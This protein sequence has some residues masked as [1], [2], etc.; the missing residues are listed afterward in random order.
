MNNNLAQRGQRHHVDALVIGSGLAGLL[1]ILELHEKAPDANIILVSKKNLNESNSWYAQGGISSVTLESDSFNQ[2]IKDTIDAGD[3]LCVLDAVKNLLKAAPNAIEKLKHYGVKFDESL[4]KEGG[5]SERRIHHIGDYTGK[6]IIQAL[7]HS[8]QKQKQIIVLENHT[9]VNLIVPGKKHIPGTQHEV[10][11]AYLLNN[12]NGK[13]DTYIAKTVVLGTGGAGKIYRYTSN[14][15]T[16][17][18]DGIA[19]AYRA[20]A[21]IGNME[22]YQFHP[23]VLHHHKI[24]NFLIT[25]ALRGEGAYLLHPE[26]LERFMQKYDKKAELA[27][28]DIVSRAI[29]TEIELSNKNFVYLD[30]RHQSREFLQQHFP[31]IFSTLLELGIDMS[32]DLIPV[33]PAAHYLCGGILTDVTGRTDLKRLYAI[34]ETAFTG[35]HGANRLASNSLLEA[36]VMAE[37]AANDTVNLLKKAMPNDHK[38]DHDID[39]WDSQSV[40]DSRRASQINAHWRGLRGE[41]TSYAGIVRTEAGLKDLL[42]LIQARREMIEDYYWKYTVTTDLIELR[43]I[44]LVA[45]LIVRSALKRQESRGGHYREDYPQKSY[46][47]KES[48]LIGNPQL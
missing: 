24:N 9:A 16:A 5:H 41:M 39:D 29:F 35:L 34:G 7:I 20:G 32:K 15:E 21:R 31:S 33:V 36:A 10:I 45:E 26:T 1:Y 23:T 27:T 11:G 3:G 18:G 6:A 30:I 8:L 13:I 19:M 14:P 17:T 47:S 38:A 42:H 43:N 2:H 25:E 22:F 40:I 12:L 46:K 4:A 44:S 37:L 28:R 48:V